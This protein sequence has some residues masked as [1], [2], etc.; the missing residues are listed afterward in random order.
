[1]FAKVFTQIFDSSIADDYE[2]RHVFEDL[3]K[4]SDMEGVVDMTIEAVA[5]RTNVPFEIV[6]RAI[7][8]LVAP[9][10]RSRSPDYEGRRLLP[11][12]ERRGWGWKIVNY[13]VYRE[14][15][16]EEDRKEYNREAKRRE[17]AKKKGM[18]ADKK[19]KRESNRM[20]EMSFKGLG[21]SKFVD[22]GTELGR[23]RAEERQAR[24]EDEAANRIDG[25]AAEHAAK[26]KA[27][28]EDRA[29]KSDTDYPL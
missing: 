14:I 1:M 12:D 5:R 9:D 10:S 23:I 15:R 19:R 29:A 27:L 22:D 6:A 3:L 18:T 21:P 25:Q 8:V 11:L 28:E 24:A 7:G 20:G 16:N 26:K 4:L 2:V 13:G 17:R